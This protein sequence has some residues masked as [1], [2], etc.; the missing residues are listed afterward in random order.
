ML[1]ILSRKRTIK[2]LK[3]SF[4]KWQPITIISNINVHNEVFST[5][6]YKWHAR[7]IKQ[8]LPK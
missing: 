1:G 4:C 7:K 5:V 8:T 2:Y 3:E 6:L